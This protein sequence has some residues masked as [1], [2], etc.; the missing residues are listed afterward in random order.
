MT[1]FLQARAAPEW[2]ARAQTIIAWALLWAMVMLHLIR[3]NREQRQRLKEAHDGLELYWF[4]RK[5]GVDLPHL[6]RDFDDLQ[7]RKR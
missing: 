5:Q 7:K 3:R 1:V 2:V 6:R 4:M